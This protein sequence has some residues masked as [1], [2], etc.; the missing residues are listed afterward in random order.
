MPT[1]LKS[2][3]TFTF[4]P[5][6]INKSRSK[7]GSATGSVKYVS[8]RFCRVF[9]YKDLHYSASD[10]QSEVKSY[11]FFVMPPL[12][13]RLLPIGSLRSLQTRFVRDFGV[14]KVFIQP[15]GNGVISNIKMFN[16]SSCGYAKRAQLTNCGKKLCFCLA[17]ESL[18]FST[19]CITGL[20]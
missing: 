18:G 20:H 8:S 5:L 7:I 6:P 13:T 15:A 4:V 14:L 11:L 19:I 3:S 2:Y 1:F 10:C 16:I 12:L 17:G 9:V